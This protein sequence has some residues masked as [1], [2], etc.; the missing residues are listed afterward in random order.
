[1]T[2]YKSSSK[3]SLWLTVSALP[4]LRLL[5]AWLQYKLMTTNQPMTTP[6]LPQQADET[7][8]CRREKRFCSAL[9]TFVYSNWISVIKFQFLHPF[10]YSQISVLFSVYLCFPPVIAV[11]L[12]YCLRKPI[13]WLLLPI[14]L[15]SLLSAVVLV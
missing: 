9:G 2:C 14:F 8:I 3:S 13:I 7:H 15:C 10:L 4:H 11:V 12:S 1:M 5:T 6:F